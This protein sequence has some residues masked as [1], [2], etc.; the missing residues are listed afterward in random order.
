M[1]L[2]YLTRL[3]ML[4]ALSVVLG[5]IES[6]IPL[7]S[8]IIPGFKIGLANI[9]IVFLLYHDGFKEA[10]IVSLLRVLL[11]GMM[12]TGLFNAS[13]AFSLSGALCSIVIM[14]LL[15]PSKLSIVGVSIAGSIWHSI[16]QIIVAIIIFKQLAMLSYLP[17]LLLCSIPTG[18]LVGFVSKTLVNYFDDKSNS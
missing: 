4:L 2:R 8:G 1:N 17:L 12:R 10:L 16:G 14:A 6:F 13:F 18:L 7:F 11:L 5:L 9:V 15:K 3:A